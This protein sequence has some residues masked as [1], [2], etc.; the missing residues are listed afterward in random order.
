VNHASIG[1]K[2]ALAIARP[3]GTSVSRAQ[4]PATRLAEN[5]AKSREF[6]SAG[7]AAVA[8][9][10]PLKAVQQFSGVF[11]IL[12]QTDW[13]ATDTLLVFA[14]WS[15]KIATIM[16]IPITSVMKPGYIIKMPPMMSTILSYHK[17]AVTK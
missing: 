10:S 2:Q 4:L 11:L 1:T 8:S 3:D 17:V 14:F 7:I 16:P 6:I 15:R 13:F 12:S 9:L 5:P